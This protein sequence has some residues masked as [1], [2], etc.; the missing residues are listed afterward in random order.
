MNGRKGGQE[1]AEAAQAGSRLREVWK[2]YRQRGNYVSQEYV[3][4]GIP[5]ASD[6]VVGTVGDAVLMKSS[7]GL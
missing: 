1:K 2:S 3:C 6:H 4:L 7:D 5:A